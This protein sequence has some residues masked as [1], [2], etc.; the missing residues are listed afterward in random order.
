MKTIFE[1]V[2]SDPVDQWKMAIKSKLAII[3]SLYIQDQQ[4]TQSEAANILGVTQ[5]RISNLVNARIDKFSIDMLID[6][7]IRIGYLPKIGFNSKDS[8]APISIN[9]VKK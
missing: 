5:P 8:S 6:M 7:L 4:L 2:S 3:L 1:N 9:M